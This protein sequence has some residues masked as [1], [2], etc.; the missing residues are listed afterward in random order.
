MKKI[1]ALAI[2]VLLALSL[3]ACAQEEEL[4]DTID[5]YTGGNSTHRLTAEQGGGTLTFS[6][7][8][9]ADSAI[10][11]DYTGPAK[12]HAAE[13]PTIVGDTEKEVTG[14]GDEAFRFTTTLTEITLPDTVTFIGKQA[15]AGCTALEKIVIPES[16]THIDEMAFQGCTALKTVVFE[17]NALVTID[18]FAF[19][20]CTSLENIVLPE[21]LESIGMAAFGDCKSITKL[22][23]P[24]TLKTIGEL[25][26]C[27][28]S[29]LNTEGAITL[30]ASIEEI[31]DSAFAEVTDPAS[32]YY[33]AGINKY[34][35]VAPEG[36]YA[37]EFVA[38]MPEPKVED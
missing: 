21:G 35:I 28:C 25:A 15:F 13:I 20:G 8:G 17:G 5:N 26:F 3:F 31:A 4:D 33:F 22:T 24:S 36:S 2:T 23:M 18:N 38:K 9:F 14:I 16:V 32:G 6:N 7:E 27:G 19:E 34:F 10:I 37:A 1:I 29:G 30:S 12:L 11:T